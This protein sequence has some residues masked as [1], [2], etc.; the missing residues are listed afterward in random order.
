MSDVIRVLIVED[1][2]T[3]A[4][5]AEREVRRVLP[6][7]E[8]MRVETKEDFLAA[9]ES[10]RP[11]VILSDYMLPRFDGMKALKL[12]RE[13]VPEIPFILIT[14]STNEETAVECMKAGAWDYV[15]KEHVKRLGPAV[16]NA[17]EQG[18]QRRERKRAEEALRE[19][20]IRLRSLSDNLSGGLVYQIDSGVDGQE[21]RFTYISAGVELLHGI[22]VEKAMA[23]AMTIYDQVLSEDRKLM[24]EKERAAV[25]TLEPFSAEVRM[26]LPNGETRWGYFSSTPR[27]LANGHLLWDGVEVDITERKRTEEALAASE[28]EFRRLSQEFHGLLDAIPDN[29][30]LLDKK[31]RILWANRATVNNLGKRPEELIGQSCFSVRHHRTEPCPTCPVLESFATGQPASLVITGHGTVWDLRTIPLLDENGVVSRVIEVARDI[32]AHR[33]LEAQFLQAQKMESVGRLAG[34]VAH[35]FNNMLTVVIGYGEQVMSQLQPDDPVYRDIAE[36]V[37]AARRSAELTRQLLA[38]SRQQAV[39][40]QVV[41]LNE[42]IG[43]SL[44]MLKRLV[45]E[46]IDLRL[47]PG[48]D[49]ERVLID[50]SQL[51]QILANLTVNARDAIAGS[52]LIRIETE[53]VVLDESYCSF[54]E[55]FVPGEYVMVTFSD[56]GSGIDQ[57]TLPK[58]FE[59]FFTTKEEG[60]GTGLGLSTVYG[61]VKQNCGFINVYSEP[62]QGTTFKIY[63]PRHFGPAVKPLE[64]QTETVQGGTETLLVVEDE[65]QIL[66]MCQRLLEKQGYRVLTAGSPEEAMA[67]CEQFREEIHL[68]VSDL[69]MPRMN[70]RELFEKISL[71]KPGIKVLIMSGYTADLISKKGGLTEGDHFIQKPFT[72]RDFI[73]KVRQILSQGK[74]ESSNSPL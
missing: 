50:L 26:L 71:V 56:S 11:E 68:L 4:E 33:R 44:K 74:G 36:M 38:Y 70:G 30:T 60:K 2:P 46:D 58:I 48:D 28:A 66:A 57:V 35:D 17:L 65:S 14:G 69:I 40:P 23:D 67:Q 6:G 32:T 42:R 72:N 64:V 37:K 24:A 13:K 73:L 31:M 59:P 43:S 29:L 62:G 12:A 39:L 21:R 61:I 3:D 51:D 8:F 15:V 1:L 25:A 45:G 55:G 22:S 9:L 49:L 20:E 41:D 5:L 10:F 47:A 63:F 27:R 18:R 19:S 16:L 53:N 54:H 52:G 34:G 7:S